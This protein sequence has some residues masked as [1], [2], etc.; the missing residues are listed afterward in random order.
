MNKIPPFL[1]LYEWAEIN[2]MA[3][4]GLK[5]ECM[6][7]G[8]DETF[9]EQYN[10]I[11]PQAVTSID[12]CHNVR[13]LGIIMSIDGSYNDH[14]NKV[15]SKAKQKVAWINRS[16]YNKSTQLRRKL[17]RNYI[18]S[19]MDYGSQLWSPIVPTKL[20]NL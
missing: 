17:W 18:E 7:Y 3:F 5:F 20:S 16:F 1:L 13:D 6:K 4:N 12:D 9:K 19:T 10:H 8:S 2:N 11:T 14:I 15:I